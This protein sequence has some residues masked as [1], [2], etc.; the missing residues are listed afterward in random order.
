MRSLGLT[1]QRSGQR[2]SYGGRSGPLAGG[3]HQKS[4][5]KSTQKSES[6]RPDMYKLS[7][8]VETRRS[9]DSGTRG[10]DMPKS[11]NWYNN[12][13]PQAPS[14]D[15]KKSKKSSGDNESQRSLKV[16]SDDEDPMHMMP[17]NLA[18]PTEAII[19]FIHYPCNYK[20]I[21]QYHAVHQQTMSIMAM[22]PLPAHYSSCQTNTIF[23]S[24]HCA[25]LED[26]GEYR[27][28]AYSTQHARC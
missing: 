10:A 19:I 4:T 2:P 20:D 3:A 22:R 25:P 28:S 26:C 13:Y 27:N 23:D 11:P 1:T 12:A 7:T 18:M 8:V 24:A 21:E 15:A 5:P 16:S 9:H 17:Y 14:K 6:L